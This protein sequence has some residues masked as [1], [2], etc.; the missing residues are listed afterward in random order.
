M[1]AP[2]I[3]VIGATGRI[4]RAVIDHLLR[5]GVS[6]RAVTRRPAAANL[7]AAVEVVPGDLTKPASL[8]ACLHGV[9]VVFLLWTAPD[10]T[11]PVVISQIACH[12]T[13][14]VAL[15]SPH[16]VA[17]PFFEQPNAMAALHAHLERLIAAA[18]VEFTILRPGVF[19]SNA[20]AWWAPTIRDGDVVRW[21]YGAAEAAPIDE[22]DIAAVAAHALCEDGHNG[23]EYVLTGPQSLS[24]VEQVRIIGE[25]I[26]RR[27]RFEEMRA[28]DFRREMT[29]QAP[30]PWVDMLLAAWRATLGH[31]ALVTSTVAAVTG[32]PARTFRH[33]AG[34]HVNAFL[35]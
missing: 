30:G 20:L 26:G 7:P 27:L 32:S 25:V 15:T 10:A 3:M 1:V 5:A 2:M 21:P 22:R 28:E 4:G 9:D 18:G 12:A 24:Q 6:V 34:D 13:R 11:L 8:V 35:S 31:R 16:Q 23:A 29:R 19:A 14:I 17:H 33:W